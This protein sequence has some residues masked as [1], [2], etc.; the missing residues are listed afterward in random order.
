MQICIY[1][2]ISFVFIVFIVFFLEEF[3]S[4]VYEIN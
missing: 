4:V 1:A 3:I 2:N